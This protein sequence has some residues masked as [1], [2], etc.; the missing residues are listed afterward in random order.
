M[1]NIA[2]T[3]WI[4]QRATA[5]TLVPLLIWFLSI[6]IDLIQKDYQT[7][8]VFFEN[9][10]NFF[11]SII[12]LIVVFLHMKIGT[13]EIFED[14]IQNTQYK[15]F[16]NLIISLFAIILPLLTIVSLVLIKFY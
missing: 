10:I 3:K 15:I 2:V 13:S 16:A 7:T 6:F 9:D 4:M 5:I 12:F 1:M 11:L 14:Y 8:L